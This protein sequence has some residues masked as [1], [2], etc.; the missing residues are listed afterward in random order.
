MS[1]ASYRCSTPHGVYCTVLLQKVQICIAFIGI[2]VYEH[3]TLSPSM[4]LLIIEDDLDLAIILKEKFDERGYATDICDDGEKGSYLIRTNTYDVIIVDLNLPGKSGAEIAFEMRE[5]GIETPM[6]VISTQSELS[7]KVKHLSHWADDYITKPFSFDE[8]AARVL[9]C[10]RRPKTIVSTSIT[11][12]DI[13]INSATYE[14][15]RA[16]KKIKLTK[17]EFALL[18]LLMRNQNNCVS[19][20]DIL[21]HVWDKDADPVSNTIEAHMANL[22]RKL[23][24][25][26]LPDLVTCLPNTGY[27]VSSS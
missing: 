8:L 10:L 13:T 25:E 5:K 11:C 3:D 12:G 26:N 14:T 22:K 21:E 15:V 4:R 27:K 6:L 17:K 9:A 18:E 7:E 24:M 16:G 23:R 19:R 2:S 20:A 1:L